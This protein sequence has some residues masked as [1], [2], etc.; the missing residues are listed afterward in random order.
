MSGALHRARRVGHAGKFVHRAEIAETIRTDDA[1]AG[2]RNKIGQE[3]MP[4]RA[5][6]AADFF[7]ATGNNVDGFNFFRF[8]L[9]ERVGD[10]A[11]GNGKHREINAILNVI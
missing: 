10:K 11:R 6:R 7:K 4:P 9:R 5:F 8:A 3:L 2:A 1:N